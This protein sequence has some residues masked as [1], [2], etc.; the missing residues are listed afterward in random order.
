MQDPQ[1]HLMDITEMSR[2]AGS[3]IEIVVEESG[4]KAI[5]KKFTRTEISCRSFNDN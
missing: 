2:S 4:M 5:T 1:Y 3:Y